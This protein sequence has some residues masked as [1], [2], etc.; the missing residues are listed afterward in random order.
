MDYKYKQLEDNL[1]NDGKNMGFYKVEVY[2]NNEVV[3][4]KEVKG[5]DRG[6]AI[7]NVLTNLYRG[8]VDYVKAEKLSTTVES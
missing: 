7:T 8:D 6:R 5:K 4:T 1:V 2:L 3:Y